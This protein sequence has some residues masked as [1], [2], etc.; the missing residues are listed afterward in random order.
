MQGRSGGCRNDHG[1]RPWFQRV[2]A[3]ENRLSSA[4]PL[5]RVARALAPNSCGIAP[6]LSGRVS[7]REFSVK[8]NK[9]PSQEADPARFYR[10]LFAEGGVARRLAIV[11]MNLFPMK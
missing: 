6:T 11:V 9:K 2:P 10:G 5:V 1:V 3:L 7:S 8:P 4:F